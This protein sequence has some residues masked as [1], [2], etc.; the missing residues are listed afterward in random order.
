METE[1]I[2]KLILE[3]DNEELKKE[4]E[5]ARLEPIS[6]KSKRNGNALF[7]EDLGFDDVIYPEADNAFERLRTKLY[8]RFPR[9]PWFSRLYKSRKGR[10]ERMKDCDFITP[11]QFLEAW[12]IAYP[13]DAQQN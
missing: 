12:K 2:V 1:E 10:E 5:E 7:R 6:V 9:C 8:L 4:I 11:E 3:E 13:E